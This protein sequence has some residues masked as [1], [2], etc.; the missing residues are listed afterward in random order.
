MS[1]LGQKRTLLARGPNV[2]L[3]SK[4]KWFDARI[5]ELTLSC[6]FALDVRMVRPCGGGPQKSSARPHAQLLSRIFCGFL[7]RETPLGRDTPLSL[8]R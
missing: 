5:V 3:T 6:V 4:M 7:K 2:R 1:A 8:A